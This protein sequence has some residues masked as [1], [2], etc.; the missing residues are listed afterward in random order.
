MHLLLPRE[1]KVALLLGQAAE[2][3]MRA[4][5]AAKRARAE[6]EACAEEARGWDADGAGLDA[7]GRRLLQ[8]SRSMA[9]ELQLH[10]SVGAFVL[11]DIASLTCSTTSH[12]LTCTTSHMSNTVS[13][14]LGYC[15]VP[16]RSCGLRLW[17]IEQWFGLW[18]EAEA[19]Q[20]DVKLLQA[21]SAQLRRDLELKY[22][23]E[24]QYA[25]RSVLQVA[26]CL[27][28]AFFTIGRIL[29]SKL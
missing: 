13:F 2:A 28:H 25:Q 29:W 7:R 4:L 18:Q 15:S 5:E 3:D 9:A 26:S 11:I 12:N 24:V 27:F 6:A 17:F 20:K 16:G 21:E 22:E 1:R 19:L 8:E 14:S 23:M 10:I